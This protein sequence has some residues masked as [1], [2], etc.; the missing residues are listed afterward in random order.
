MARNRALLIA[1]I[2]LETFPSERSKSDAVDILVE[3]SDSCRS[4]QEAARCITDELM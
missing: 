2:H 1:K 4:T 3:V